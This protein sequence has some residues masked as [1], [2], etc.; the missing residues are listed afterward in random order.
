[1]ETVADF[2]FL[3][4][5]ITVDCD[6]HDCSHEIKRCLLLGRKAMTISF[7]FPFLFFFI[8]YVW[9]VFIIRLGLGLSVFRFYFVLFLFLCVCYFCWVF[10][11]CYLSWVSF[12]CFLFIFLVLS[13][14]S[15][16][17]MWLAGS[18]Y[19]GQGLTWTS[20]VEMLSPGCCI[21]REV[22]GPGNIN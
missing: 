11:Y 3:G 9:I 22:R 21:A 16:H 14:P 12:A 18:W 7:F 1:M 5:K 6:P 4:S 8:V 2:I 13:F 10:C 17:T 20:N 15:G 19:P